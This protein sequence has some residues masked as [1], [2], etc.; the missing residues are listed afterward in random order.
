MSHGTGDIRAK[1]SL[2]QEVLRFLTA[3]DAQPRRSFDG[4]A[5]EE[6]RRLAAGARFSPEQKR[7]LCALR[8][9]LYVNLGRL[10]ARRTPLTAELQVK[11]S[12]PVAA[13]TAA[14]A[15]AAPRIFVPGVEDIRVCKP[16]GGSPTRTNTAPGPILKAEPL[17][18]CHLACVRS[19]CCPQQIRVHHLAACALWR[20][21]SKPTHRPPGLVAANLSGACRSRDLL[22]SSFQ[23]GSSCYRRSGCVPEVARKKSAI[24]L[25]QG[26]LPPVE[27]TSPAASPLGCNLA[28]TN[29][30]FWDAFIAN[31]PCSL[32]QGVLPPVEPTS[33]AAS[34]V[35]CDVAC[36]SG[37]FGRIL[38]IMRAMKDTLRDEH[39]TYL[40]ANFMIWQQVPD[41][42]SARPLM[43]DG[44]S[45]FHVCTSADLDLRLSYPACA[46]IFTCFQGAYLNI[47]VRCHKPQSDIA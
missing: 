29:S 15:A 21:S 2:A 41:G 31:Q 45:D 43:S 42:P 7:V 14:P 16:G 35:G 46:Q 30:C 4:L 23:P 13:P 26:M 10:G 22:S 34:P 24:S 5:T 6:D 1:H 12:L 3:G 19:R 20:M 17:P 38:D 8:V 36:T 11:L 32:P 18:F 39:C 28:C 44:E 33:P 40:R 27:P 37:R 25:L 9:P 47:Q